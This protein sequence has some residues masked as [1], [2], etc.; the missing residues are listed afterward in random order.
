MSTLSR[1][2]NV[3]SVNFSVYLWYFLMPTHA[4]HTNFPTSGLLFVIVD[5]KSSLI[6]H[7]RLMHL[8][9]GT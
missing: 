1:I 3:V 2:L 9:E 8:Y 6:K 5:S 7:D 4:T